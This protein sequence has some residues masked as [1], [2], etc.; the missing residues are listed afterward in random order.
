MQKN[1]IIFDSLAPL[2]CSSAATALLVLPKE[3]IDKS[4]VFHFLNNAPEDKT[5]IFRGKLSSWAGID[6]KGNETKSP[7]PRMIRLSMDFS[8][9]KA[10]HVRCFGV[11][12]DEVKELVGQQ[13]LIQGSR[14]M[15]GK[16]PMIFNAALSSF[17]GKV[18]P[19][20]VGVPGL[21]SG[22]KI[23]QGIKAALLEPSAVQEAAE[24]VSSVLP[25][26]QL[27]QQR[28]ISSVQ[29]IKDLHTP[30]TL[31]SAETAL[32][33]ARQ[34]VVAEIRHAAKTG[35]APTSD[36]P[37]RY[38]IDAA[39]IEAVKA[40]KETL[41]PDQRR[42][43]NEIRLEFNGKSG[44]RILLNGDVG[45]GKTLVFLLA[46]A[47]V[48]R[49]TRK[50]VA[51]V[52]P[53]DLVARQIHA[54]AQARFPDLKPALV[55]AGADKPTR[56]AKMLIGT[57]ALFHLPAMQKL[58]ALVIDEQH[59]F[60]VEQ[61][62]ILAH[63]H[64]HIIE[65]SATPIPRSLALAIF[66]GWK[67]VKIVNGPVP[68]LIRACIAIPRH[69]GSVGG[70]VRQHI[71]MGKKIIFLYHRVTGEGASVIDAGK[72]LSERFP[73]KVSILHGKLKPAEKQK[74]LTAF[75]TGEQPI[76]VASTAVEVGVDVA[77]IGLMVVSNAD[78]FG[79]AQLHQLRGRLA[80][81]GGSA[82]FVMMVDKQP[83]GTTLERLN[84]V[85]NHSDGFS[86][87][88]RDM[89]IRGFG[90]ILGELQSGKFNGTFKLARLDVADFLPGGSHDT[91]S[92]Q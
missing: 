40:Q 44:A 28:G 67:Q 74:A 36:E 50:R 41:S 65:A 90:D 25:I 69:R 14:R 86:L 78:K 26:S 92:A 56:A 91:S 5:V 12:P 17:T 84:A 6:A 31:Q 71:D 54:Q 87:A 52:V 10:L 20:Y 42:A 55:I 85:C 53:S 37:A 58:E 19:Q 11:K 62:K 46:I 64:T 77:D 27:L 4:N 9:A 3:Y 45:T 35:N 32:A 72:R 7:F 38:N 80:R 24:I 47:A 70:L 81:N 57:Q 61:R 89:E 33:I 13:I 76:I 15:T 63:A 16:G 49:T 48:A 73:S 39:L 22:D 51:V 43:L 83:A 2:G 66:D 75:A 23:E 8:D 60:S 29:L 79:V 1:K 21:I 82:D 68:K 59:K 88:E 18:E 30:A 34:A